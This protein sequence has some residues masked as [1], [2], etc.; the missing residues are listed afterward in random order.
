MNNMATIFKTNFPDLKLKTS[1]KVR[2]I[3][4]LDDHYLFVA[5]DRISAF[6]VIMDQP[7][8]DKGHILSNISVFWF[9]QTKDIIRNHFV[10][11]DPNEYPN[12]CK[13]Y[14]N[15]LEG[16]SM[17]VKKCRPLP[18][19]CIVRDYLAGSGWKEYQKSR[20]ICDIRLP[21]GLMEYSR[22]PEAIYTPSTK[23]VK[24]H[25]E[26]INFNKSIEIIG[27]KLAE[28]LREKSLELF[29]YAS[30]HLYQRGIILADTKF[31]FGLDDDDDLVLIDEAITPDSSRFWLKESYSPGEQQINFDKQ[32][33][34]D[35]LESISWN[36]Q[37]P[38]PQLPQEIIDKTREKYQEAFKRIIK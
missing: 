28:E 17:L 2:D 5:T 10:T 18:I 4:D 35:Y 19:E 23:A 9:N 31:E 16:R 12:E 30:D 36:K 20:S 8:P 22:L 21:E 11:N 33:L 7:I 1:G 13:P 38:P 37:P 6:D 32:I 15:T 25:D 29:E 24:G 14:I 3:Y 26:N 27:K 34:R